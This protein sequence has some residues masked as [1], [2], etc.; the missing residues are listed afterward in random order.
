M[1]HSLALSLPVLTSL[2]LKVVE[3]LADGKRYETIAEMMS[4]SQ[5]AV[6]QH[7][8]R[9]YNLTGT[10]SPGGLVAWAMRNGVIE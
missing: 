9:I 10:D 1:N 3:L 6:K 2:Q 5:Q 4:I 7:V 8:F